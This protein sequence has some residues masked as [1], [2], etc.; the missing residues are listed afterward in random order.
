MLMRASATGMTVIEVLVAIVIVAIA[1]GA[2]A[3]LFLRAWQQHQHATDHAQAVG[4]ARSVV[5]AATA[6]RAAELADPAACDA[7]VAPACL[8]LSATAALI[9][10]RAAVSFRSATVCLSCATS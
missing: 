5:E 3:A 2:N 6:L 8:T 7:G 1:L 10:T 4:L 9:P